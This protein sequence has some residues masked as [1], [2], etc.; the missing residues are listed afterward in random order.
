MLV[1]EVVA[2]SIC[3]LIHD[4][5]DKSISKMG[6]PLKVASIASTATSAAN[7]LKFGPASLPI[8]KAAVKDRVMESCFPKSAQPNANAHA[9]SQRSSALQS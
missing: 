6:L 8:E 9:N 3:E 1:T 7:K 4:I 2:C 5:Q